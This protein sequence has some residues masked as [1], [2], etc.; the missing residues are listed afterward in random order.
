MQSAWG[1]TLA[2]MANKSWAE[3]AMEEEAEHGQIAVRRSS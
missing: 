1:T 2:D 3:D